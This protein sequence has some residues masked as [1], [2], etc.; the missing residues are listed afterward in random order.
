MFIGF[1]A[2]I[3]SGTGLVFGREFMDQSIIDIEDGKRSLE[4]PVLGA[5][6]R[7]T[8]QE[9]IRK[10]KNKT[11][12]IITIALISAAALIAGAVAISTLKR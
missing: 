8:T 9:E 3:A 11:A 12:I 7:I 5:I 2:G 4:L 1:L 10:E 6:P